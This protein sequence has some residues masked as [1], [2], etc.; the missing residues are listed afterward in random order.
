MQNPVKGNQIVRILQTPLSKPS[1]IRRVLFK[2]M[3]P[4]HH[5]AGFTRRPLERRE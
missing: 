2:D 1:N 4:I 5:V 3:L